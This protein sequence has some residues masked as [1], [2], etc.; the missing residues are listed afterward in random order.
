MRHKL[1]T[2]LI[3]L[4]LII[5]VLVV[6]FARH[7]P[8]ACDNYAEL[9]VKGKVAFEINKMLA[10]NINENNLKYKEITTMN[11]KSDGSILSITVDTSKINKLALEFSSEIY[12]TVNKL[13]NKFAIPLGNAMGSR[14]FSGRGPDIKIRIIPVS[15]ST[16][17]IK[18]E[19]LSSGINQTLHRISIT[20]QTEIMCLAPYHE[21]KI[22]FETKIVLGETLIVGKVPEIILQR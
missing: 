17:D 6:Q 10:S 3:S 2:I 18:S 15:T 21:Y 16:F 19:L 20:F 1:I 14:L 4:I 13:D 7:Y 8:K 11:T 22:S 12:E 5:S 9:G